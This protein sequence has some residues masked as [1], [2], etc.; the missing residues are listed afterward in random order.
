MSEWKRFFVGPFD[1]KQIDG[2]HL[3][4]MVR[5]TNFRDWDE[6]ASTQLQRTARACA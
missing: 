6:R 3:F 2:H 5:T 4:V 1:L